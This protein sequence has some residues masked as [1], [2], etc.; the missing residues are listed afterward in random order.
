MSMENVMEEAGIPASEILDAAGAQPAAEIFDVVD[1]NGQPTGETVERGA[2]HAQGIRHRTAHVWVVRKREGHFEAL[3]QKRSMTKDSFPGLYDTSSAGHIHAG[4]EPL[5]S[6]MRELEEELGI[7]AREEELPFAGNFLVKY[8]RVF[9]GKPF[10]DNEIA[11]VFAYTGEVDETKLTL[12]AEEVESVRWFDL[13]A[14]ENASGDEDKIFCVPSGG[15]RTIR[16][17]LEE[18]PDIMM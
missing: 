18:N 15:L 11:Y 16:R 5:P 6:A 12:Q 3:L 1:E 7:K 13:E 4:D 14:V 10:K 8:E 9:Y 17:F 2:A